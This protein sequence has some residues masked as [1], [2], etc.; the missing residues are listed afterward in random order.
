MIVFDAGML[1]A[2]AHGDANAWVRFR[3]MRKQGMS[4]LVPAPV[5]SQVWR[6]GPAALLS[7]ALHGC[8]L[9]PFLVEHAKPVGELCAVAGSS[10]VVD[11]H[12]IYI[13]RRSA[14]VYT[15]DPDDL[16]ELIRAGG[17]PTA[18]VAV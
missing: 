1:I 4:P 16:R 18:V 14:W 17:Y 6:G 15:T 2:L 5:L 7:R 10:D 13:G 8:E 12:A 9:V 11:A 3:A